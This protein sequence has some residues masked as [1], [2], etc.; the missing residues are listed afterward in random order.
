[1][2][3]TLSVLLLSAVV[4]GLVGMV[5]PAQADE[6]L[7]QC[8]KEA[9]SDYKECTAACKDTRDSA[10]ALCK[11]NHPCEKTCAEHRHACREPILDAL[12]AAIKACN[13]ALHAAVKLRRQI[14]DPVMHDACIDAA[15]IKALIG[16]D[17]AREIA[18]PA[19]NTCKEEFKACILACNP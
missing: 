11:Q 12:E 10:I 15:Q 2:K 16:R 17:D 13:T 14:A 6:T 9:K 1:M 8:I 3:K 19:L 5:S 18:Q 7:R 4:A